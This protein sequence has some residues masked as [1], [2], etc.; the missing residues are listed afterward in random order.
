VITVQKHTTKPLTAGQK[1]VLQDFARWAM[2]GV[3]RGRLTML[4]DSS[5]PTNSR[6]DPHEI[7]DAYMEGL[8]DLLN[9]SDAHKSAMALELVVDL[10]KKDVF[11]MRHYSKYLPSDALIEQVVALY[12]EY[13]ASI[14]PTVS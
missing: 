2:G 14:V 8:N 1:T 10:I 3:V 5:L 11:L 7:I 9:V 6:V 12:N 13:L 4:V